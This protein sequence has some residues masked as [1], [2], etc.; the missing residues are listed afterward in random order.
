MKVE[1]TGPAGRGVLDEYTCSYDAG[2][3]GTMDYDTLQ[4]MEMPMPMPHTRIT[5]P[6][7]EDLGIPRE[8]DVI[9]GPMPPAY[10]IGG[11][12]NMHMPNLK[13]EPNRVGPNDPF[14]PFCQIPLP[15]PFGQ[16]DYGLE[17][18]FIRKRNE[19]ERERVRCVNDGYSRLRDHLPMENKDKRISKVETL[20]AAIKYIKSLQGLLNETH[21]NPKKRPAKDDIKD[22][23]NEENTEYKKPPAKRRAL[24]NKTPSNSNSNS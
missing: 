17:P 8:N 5:S 10:Y 15:H 11:Q 3:G 4:S 1:L 23:E 22:N 14:S 7:C 16:Y 9:D 24:Q 18:A 21:S 19:R 13:Y 2:G 6:T 20:R 12:P